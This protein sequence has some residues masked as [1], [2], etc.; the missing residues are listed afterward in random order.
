VD[1][2]AWDS[3]GASGDQILS[4][5]VTVLQPTVTVST[6]VSGATVGSPVNIL[7]SATPTAG[8]TISGWCI[9]VDGSGVYNVGAVARINASVT[10]AVGAYTVIVR[11]WD[12]SGAYGGQTLAL[13]SVTQ[14]AVSVST[15]APAANV[16]SPISIQA[17]AVP[18]SGHSITGWHIYLD[19]VSMYSGGAVDSIS[20][21]VAA[22]AGT[23]TLV[24]R[25]WDSSKAFGDQTFTVQVQPVAVNLSTPANGA[26]VNSPVNIAA[27]A[28][29]ANAISAWQ[30]YVDSVSAFAQNGGN[31]IDAN[32]I[33]SQG[34]HSIVVRAWD[35]TG[36][37][38]SQSI[39]A[40]VP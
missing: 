28:A 5:A 35:T 29:S 24:V 16:V 32:L 19:G 39:T 4:V 7:A 40:T 10:L 15:P 20:S 38:G 2:R 21:N 9:Y 12:T 37:Y 30:V 33:M 17:S 6:P 34:T 31:S 1:V 23:H 27:T 22:S 11:A 26:S 36:A 18:S 14:P 13:T 25:A 8:H 3:S